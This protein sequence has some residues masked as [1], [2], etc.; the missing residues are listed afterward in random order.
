MKSNLGSKCWNHLKGAIS[1]C[2]WSNLYVLFIILQQYFRSPRPVSLSNPSCTPDLSISSQSKG[3]WKKRTKLVFI[4]ISSTLYS[5]HRKNLKFLHNFFIFTWFLSWIAWVYVR[6]CGLICCLIHMLPIV[7]LRSSKRVS[8]SNSSKSAS[9]PILP[10]KKIL[11][12]IKKR[13]VSASIFS[14]HLM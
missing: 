11:T 12:K 5:I 1:P 4:L 7:L 10:R 2:P 14:A 13:F 6:V 8:S 9:V 3:H